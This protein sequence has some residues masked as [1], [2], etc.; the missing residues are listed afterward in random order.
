MQRSAIISECQRYR[1]VLER[2]WQP[3]LPGVL[4]VAL[5]PST[6]D[7]QHDDPTVRRCVGFARSWGFGK[8]VIANLFALRS[9]HPS[10]LLIDVDPIGPENDWWRAVTASGSSTNSSS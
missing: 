6:A 3:E 4:F 10:V 5:N 7:G 1:Y 2:K 9:S 8:I